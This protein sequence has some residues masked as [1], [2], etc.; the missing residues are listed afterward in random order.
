MHAG[1]RHPPVFDF[2]LQPVA[3]DRQ[4]PMQRVQHHCLNVALCD[5]IITF[6]LTF[7]FDPVIRAQPE[8]PE[9]LRSASLE[10]WPVWIPRIGTSTFSLRSFDSPR[11]PAL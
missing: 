9:A 2:D 10:Q 6:L 4:V 11:I 7:V 8:A 3:R 1:H 5:M